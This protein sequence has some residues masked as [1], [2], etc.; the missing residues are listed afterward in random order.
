MASSDDELWEPSESSRGGGDGL[1]NRVIDGDR[2]ENDD[3]IVPAPGADGEGGGQVGS[4]E[5][6]GQV[7]PEGRGRAR[8]RVLAG[9]GFERARS[10]SRLVRGRH[11]RA[12]LEG[13]DLGI[14]TADEDVGRRHG[15]H[16]R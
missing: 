1:L 5:G 3:D 14:R 11:T 12:E 16:G 4:G 9:D 13:G 2:S 10:R 15:R 7:T 6:A 8:G